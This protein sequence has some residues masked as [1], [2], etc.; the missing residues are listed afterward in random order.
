MYLH[1]RSGKVGWGGGG[2]VH[3][4]LTVFD[5]KLRAVGLTQSL[6]PLTAEREDVGS[7]LGAGPTLR[8][9]K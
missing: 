3:R 6:E 4:Q 9:L 7:I 1:D 2:G 5:C 8:V